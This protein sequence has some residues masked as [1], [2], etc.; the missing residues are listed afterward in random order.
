MRYVNALV[1][2][3]STLQ[4]CKD[5]LE[6]GNLEIIFRSSIPNNIENWKGFDDDAQIIRFINNF[7]DFVHNEI[8]WR[9]EGVEYQEQLIDNN[10]LTSL[11]PL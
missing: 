2:V 9:E 6:G 5:L 4:P 7:Q 1:V 11:V 8:N 3:S 10:I